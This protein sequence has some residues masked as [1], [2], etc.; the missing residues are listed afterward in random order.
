MNLCRC[1]EIDECRENI[2]K[3]SEALAYASEA[4]HYS[5]ELG[6]SMTDAETGTNSCI[7]TEKIHSQTRHLQDLH[8]G[9]MS[10]CAGIVRKISEEKERMEA[11]LENL[12]E[13]DRR[14]HEEQWEKDV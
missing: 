3:L 12:T 9:Y 7:N 8:S 5:S 10:A 11:E 13:Q 4:E 14:Y 1:A 6:Q 2:K